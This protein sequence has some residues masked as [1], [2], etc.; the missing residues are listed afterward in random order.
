M[1]DIKIRFSADDT[2]FQRKLKIMQ[3]KVLKASQKMQEIGRKMSIGVTAPIVALGAKSVDSL[4]KIDKLKKGL[5]G[6]LGSAELASKEFERLRDLA[7]EPGLSLDSVVEGSI[8][9]QA[10]GFSANKAAAAIKIFGNAVALVGGT[11]EDLAGVNLAISQIV[12]KGKVQAEEINQIAERLPQVRKAMQDA[13]GTADT[14]VL[15]K[16]GLSAEEFVDKI[17]L[18]LSKLPEAQMSVRDSLQNMR[19]DITVMFASLGE[20]LAPVITKVG[21]F[22]SKISK[23]I[24]NLNPEA[25][26]FI[27]I[28]GGVL[29]VAGPLIAALG[30]IAIAVTAVSAA[31][32]P[33]TLTVA[34][35]V[36]ALGGLVAVGLWVKDNWSEMPNFFKRTFAQIYNFG[37]EIGEKIF[38]VLAWP[39]RKIAEL[40]GKEIPKASYDF[41][42]IEVPERKYK[43]MKETLFGVANEMKGLTKLTKEFNAESNESLFAGNYTRTPKGGSGE[44]TKSRSSVSVAAL[45][46]GFIANAETEFLKS[47]KKIQSTSKDVATRIAANMKMA[48]QESTDAFKSG[49]DSIGDS[50]AKMFDKLEEFWDEY[51]K[52]IT[53]ALQLGG[54][55]F[56]QVYDNKEAR[57]DNYYE[58]EKSRI[59]NSSASEEQKAKRIEKL[60]ESIAQRKR[61]I[62]R[63]EAAANKTKAI[64]DSIINGFVAV[65]EN[66]GN[67]VL[68][69]IIGALAAANTAA[70]ASQPLPALAKGGIVGQETAV[71]VGEYPGS[72]F[73]PEVISPLDKLQGMLQGT[74]SDIKINLMG[75]WR[76]SGYDLETVLEG[77]R[78]E[79]SRLTA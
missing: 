28:L 62:K 5:E 41:A 74:M 16:M 58:K 24:Q 37:V 57:L 78:S 35:I 14:E 31:M 51:G 7:R 52:G 12:S 48:A 70:I 44:T 30:G 32:S 45:D 1:S 63:K 3:K 55:L 29:A 56:T 23:R 17:T 68:A 26:R 66:I 59:E 22:I 36:A 67:P 21:N 71:V 43:T 18:E 19:D 60:E 79:R 27:G 8:K 25:K 73:N 34:A 33:V 15:Q 50:L 9:L 65:S 69:A 53:T 77:A 61:A 46:G 20:I 13:F 47:F 64:F 38:N 10:I 39:L 40:L 11:G 4:A 76:V 72:S 42:K 75:G 49:S 54:Q 2:D 6:M